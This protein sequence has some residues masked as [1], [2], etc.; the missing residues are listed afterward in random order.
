MGFGSNVLGL[1][2]RTQLVVRPIIQREVRHA[3]STFQG[4]AGILT[5][6]PSTTPFGLA[7]GSD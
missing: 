6:C 3:A 4:G 7:L 1:A 2:A 5:R